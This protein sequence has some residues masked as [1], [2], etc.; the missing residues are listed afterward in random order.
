M[1]R[2]VRVLLAIRSLV[3]NNTSRKWGHDQIGVADW[4]RIADAEPA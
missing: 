3:E 4:E 2:V 1:T